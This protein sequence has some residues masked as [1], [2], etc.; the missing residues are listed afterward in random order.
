MQVS[1]YYRYWQNYTEGNNDFLLKKKVKLAFFKQLC[2]ESFIIWVVKDGSLVNLE[3]DP[4]WNCDLPFFKEQSKG[5]CDI[6]WQFWITAVSF[7]SDK[8]DVKLKIHL[9]V[10]VTV[11]L[12]P[13]I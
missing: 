12:A 6:V 1:D 2:S 7:S 3:W 10:L 8:V 13:F 4:G 5:W 9:P 11:H